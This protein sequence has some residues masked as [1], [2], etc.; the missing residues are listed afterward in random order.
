MTLNRL[1]EPL[2]QIPFAHTGF[3]DNH[4]QHQSLSIHQQ[5][6]FATFYTLVTVKAAM[7]PFS[8][9]FT[10]WLSMIPALGVASRPICWRNCSRN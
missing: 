4:V 1:Q 5:M 7:P 6:A 3:T 10:D 2:C 8:V 9:V